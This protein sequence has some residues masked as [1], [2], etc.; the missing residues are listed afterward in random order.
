MTEQTF[1]AK[2][3]R[4]A[5]DLTIVNKMSEAMKPLKARIAEDTDD[6]LEYLGQ[7]PEAYSKIQKN[8][9]TAVIGNVFVSVGF[10]DAVTRKGG[11]DENDQTWLAALMQNIRS[12]GFVRSRLS[13]DKRAVLTAIDKGETD[14]R[15]LKES[16]IAIEKTQTL[17]AALIESPEE[18]ARLV[19][20]A[21]GRAAEIDE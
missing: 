19:D 6:V 15:L 20:D 21:E 12:S 16:G 9:S 5:K 14:A 4:L 13:L 18:L 10:G 1:K 17:K 11:K 8:V 7:H 2:V 3:N